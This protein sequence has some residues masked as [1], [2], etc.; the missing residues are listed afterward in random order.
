MLFLKMKQEKENSQFACDFHLFWFYYIGTK[1]GT[2]L[3]LKPTN[4]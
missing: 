2:K 1:S 3:F 4:I